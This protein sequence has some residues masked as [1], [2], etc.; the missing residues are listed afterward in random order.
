MKKQPRVSFAMID[1]KEGPVIAG[2]SG[3]GGS[4]GT[5]SEKNMRLMM[6]AETEYLNRLLEIQREIL[7]QLNSEMEPEPETRMTYERL[8][9]IESEENKLARDEL[10]KGADNLYYS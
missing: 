5:D 10:K 7:D 6:R 8:G 3:S 9:E 4:Y 1:A 2:D